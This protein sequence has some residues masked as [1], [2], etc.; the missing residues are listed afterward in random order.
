M[1][2]PRFL[3]TSRPGKGFA[4]YSSPATIIPIPERLKERIRQPLSASNS[5]NFQSGLG[6]TLQEPTTGRCMVCTYLQGTLDEYKRPFV[7]SHSA[8]LSVSEYQT[9][10]L[11]FDRTI[12]A[13]LREGVASDVNA[14]GNIEPLES[15]DSSG[16]LEI[17]EEELATL[18]RF[19]DETVLKRLLACLFAEKSFTLRIKESPDT[20][21]SLAVT[22]LKLAAK[23]GA[24]ASIAT[25]EP[26][27][28][29][30]YMSRV[31]P[32]AKLRTEFE[33]SLSG[34]TTD[35]TAVTVAE[36]VAIDVLQGNYSGIA[37]AI[38]S[39]N[40]RAETG[41]DA[42]LR[43]ASVEKAASKPAPAREP[44]KPPRRAVAPQPETGKADQ[45]EEQRKEWIG[46]W[47]AKLRAIKEHLDKREGDLN[48][49]EKRLNEQETTLKNDTAQ[50]LRDQKAM[51]KERAEVKFWKALSDADRILD[52][53][54]KKGFQ[55]AALGLLKPKLEDLNRDLG[56]RDK[57]KKG[58]VISV[59][60][61]G[62]LMRR[63][64][65]IIDSGK[66]GSP[67]FRDSAKCQDLIKRLVEEAKKSKG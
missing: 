5:R 11:H 35:R 16:R 50:L 66:K 43:T 62:E 44:E 6:V 30:L 13:P 56:G 65:E 28:R 32:D 38:D 18:N 49:W 29:S 10:A 31:L 41:R 22:L 67:N 51:E 1:K 36:R 46:D 54:L 60:D 27:D 3:Y 9:Q 25:F 59:V 52:R 2:L 57:N 7:L 33:F 21:I 34:E 23:Q 42:A 48:R 47:D 26:A 55:E 64:N 14:N 8:L 4:S 45:L 40:S 53:E 37:A 39:G 20:A 15:P 58:K 61:D 17:R 12:L 19:T 24:T 63:F